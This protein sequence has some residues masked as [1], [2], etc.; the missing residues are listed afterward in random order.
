MSPRKLPSPKGAV[1]ELDDDDLKG[2]IIIHKNLTQNLLVTTEDKMK[3]ALIEHRDALASRDEW[4]GAG[5]LIF[6]FMSPLLIANFR[7]IGP[8]TADTWRT[9]YFLFCAL[10]FYRFI[11]VLIKTSRNR[12]KAKI[13][14]LINQMKQTRIGKREDTL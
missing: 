2:E 13:D 3:L 6:S 4:V 14:Y 7:D 1:I 11:S 9:I 8:I 5:A 12:N 10:A